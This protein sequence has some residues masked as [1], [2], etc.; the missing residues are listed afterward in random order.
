MLID[1]LC[2]GSALKAKHSLQDHQHVIIDAPTYGQEPTLI[3]LGKMES[4]PIRKNNKGEADCGL[5]FHAK[6]TPMS[7]V[8]I[9]AGDTD[10]YMYGLALMEAGWLKSQEGVQ[11]QIAVERR[12]EKE[13]VSLNKGLTCIS[14]HSSLAHLDRKSVV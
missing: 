9:V 6:C 13:Y 8:L 7:H 10:V 1:Y 2:N 11:K 4:C 14:N 12:F 5:W 3:S